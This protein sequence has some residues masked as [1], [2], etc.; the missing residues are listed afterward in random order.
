MAD[1]PRVYEVVAGEQALKSSAATAST[2]DALAGI[3]GTW[4][5]MPQMAIVGQHSIF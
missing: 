4:G 5:K 3:G 1:K 2:I